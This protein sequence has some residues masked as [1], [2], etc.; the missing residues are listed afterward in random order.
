MIAFR[1]FNLFSGVECVY[2]FWLCIPQTHALTMD[3]MQSIYTFENYKDLPSPFCPGNYTFT[4]NL[5]LH[6][7]CISIALGICLK[8]AEDKMSISGTLI[9]NRHGI[10]NSNHSLAL[11]PS[12]FT[13]V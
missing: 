13:C 7:T 1:I 2:E 10:V 9:F 5:C 6:V 4:N 3:A 11:L 12:L 8:H